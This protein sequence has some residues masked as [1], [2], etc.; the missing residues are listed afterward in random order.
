MF[1][2][3]LCARA[4]WPQSR[5]ASRQK[6]FRYDE[7]VSGSTTYA[8]VSN[9]PINA[10]DPT[11]MVEA[12][13]I[14]F[15]SQAKMAWNW[16][17]AKYDRAVQIAERTAISADALALQLAGGVKSQ[18]YYDL[19]HNGQ[20]DAW[21]HAEWNRSMA[22]DPQV[23]STFAAL[24]GYGHEAAN[25]KDKVLGNGI[26]GQTWGQ[27]ANEVL[28]DSSNNRF[29]RE[30]AAL[31]APTISPRNPGLVFGTGGAQGQPNVSFADYVNGANNSYFMNNAAGGGFLLYPGK[32][33][34]NMMQSV[35][36]K[37]PRK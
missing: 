11:G 22:S 10:T 16:V 36:S 35:Y 15:V 25:L 6:C 31:G 4:G 9:N 28:M 13:L 8:Y 23:G 26:P 37:D 5:A 18:T 27:F 2:D 24:A 12:N 20:V 7:R 19:R 1:F 3:S 34:L 33:N 14:P 17:S 32:S 30:Q 29:G 21:R